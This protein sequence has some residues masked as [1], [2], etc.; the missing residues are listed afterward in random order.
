M[1]HVICL[2]PPREEHE[3]SVAAV[4]HHATVFCLCYLSLPLS[5]LIVALHGDSWDE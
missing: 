3:Q 5:L 4:A 2:V 1:Q